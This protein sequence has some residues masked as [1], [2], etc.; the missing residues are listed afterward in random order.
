[1]A[2]TREQMVSLAMKYKGAVRGSSK[3]KDLIDT[4]NRVHPHGEHM[5]YT[6][7]WCAATVTALLIKGGYTPKTMPMSCSC[8]QLI[9]DTKALEKKGLAKWVEDDAW[10]GA[11]PGDLII[12]YW[13][14]PKH[15]DCKKYTS[16]VGMIYKVT[17]KGY[18]VIEGNKHDKVAL[19]TVP[20]DWQ[21][22][23]GFCHLHYQAA[24]PEKKIG[25]LA[26]DGIFGKISIK[27]A[28]QYFGTTDDGY[29]SGQKKAY[30]KY[31]KG[32]E[33]DRIK[34]GKGGS[35]LV[36]AIQKMVEVPQTG[37]LDKG[38]VIALQHFLGIVEDG[39][40]GKVTS[41]SFQFWL[42][43]KLK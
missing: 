7:A 23:R 15:G 17:S 24:K 21:Y 38:T 29:I 14:A 39:K 35:Q 16:H 33:A 25:K 26:V 37:V 1:M 32:I 2:Y 11:Q 3:H 40:W 27:R 34:Y 41:K 12:Y 18:E 9:R 8:A 30:R 10:R 19:R 31:Y 36:K 6:R 4:F 28:Q 22:I 42:N 20:F 43:S 5:T 13:H